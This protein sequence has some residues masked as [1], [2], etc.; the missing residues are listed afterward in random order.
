M[1]G[2]G[3]TPMTPDEIKRK[4]QGMLSSE[5]FLSDPMAG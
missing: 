2:T 4:Y 3:M 5:I 1:G